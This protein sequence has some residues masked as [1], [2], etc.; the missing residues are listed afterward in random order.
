MCLGVLEFEKLH[1][2]DYSGETSREVLV[3]R[4]CNNNFTEVLKSK[5]ISSVVLFH[6]MVDHA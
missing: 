4:K 3:A 2:L 6:I 1:L 5:S